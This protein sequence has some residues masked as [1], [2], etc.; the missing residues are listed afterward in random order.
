MTWSSVV[1]ASHGEATSAVNPKRVSWSEVTTFHGV[2][3]V[4]LSQQMTW[5]SVAIVSHGEANAVSPKRAWSEEVAIFRGEATKVVLRKVVAAEKPLMGIVEEV[6][7]V[8]SFS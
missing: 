3:N 6:G 2:A 7:D 5:L 1:I 8:F 4:L